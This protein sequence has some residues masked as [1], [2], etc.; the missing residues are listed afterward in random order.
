MSTA[1]FPLSPRDALLQAYQAQSL[2]DVP[3]PAAVIDVAKVK[4]NC[5]SMLNAVEEL[6]VSFRAHVKTHK[7]TEITRLQV[8]EDCNDVRLIVS[9][10]IEAE[11]LV[12]LLLEYKSRNAKINVL[13]GVPLGPS[14]VNR[15]ATVARQLGQGSITV[16][17]DH[18]EQLK[19]LQSFKEKAG[20][21]ALVFIKTDS[22]YHRAGLIP[23]SKDM[24]DLVHEVSI[25]E[26]R[27]YLWLLG[28]YSHNSLSYGGSSPDDAMDTLKV[29]IDVCRQASQ[30]FKRD[31][32][33]PLL[34]SVGASPTALSLQNILP[35]AASSTPSANALKDTLELTKSNLELEIHA[36][37]YPIFDIQQVAASSRSFTSDPHDTIAVSVLAE[38]CS[39]YPDRTKQP[40]AL[41]SAGVLA[42]AREPCK[43]YPGW[44]VVSP[45]NMP[46]DY[47]TTK[48]DRIIV[49]RISQEHGILAFEDRDVE[50]RQLPLRY[51]QKLRIWPNHACITLAMFS[52]YYIVDTDTDTP[53]KIVDIWIRW[54]GW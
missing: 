5:I 18:P 20:F 28:F 3:V 31:R 24:M 44:G 15:L 48:K 6:G 34:V 51:G 38:V 37:V 16:M 21:P 47:G 12:P 9:T 22:G 43:D 23:D 33:T 26:Q 45:W 52:W 41:I 1:A 49:S 7:T 11:Q 46:G 14:H 29:E 35:S 54:R 13:Y 50:N 42:L 17:I 8:G 40:E 39:L 27:G 2:H 32:Q 36:G 53:D 25:G 4:A 30:H 10:I 19:C